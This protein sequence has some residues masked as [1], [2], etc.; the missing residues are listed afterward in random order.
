[1]R[2]FD[3]EGLCTAFPTLSRNQ[4]EV[5]E[6]EDESMKIRDTSFSFHNIGFFSLPT[7]RKSGIPS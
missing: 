5:L 7:A 1:M 3:M 2:A 6:D 4:E